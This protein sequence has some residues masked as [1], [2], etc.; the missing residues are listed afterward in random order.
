M[1]RV[2]DESG[3]EAGWRSPLLVR[4]LR[5]EAAGFRIQLR[6]DHKKDFTNLIRRG[7]IEDWIYILEITFLVSLMVSTDRSE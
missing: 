3:C 5:L 7:M 6:N 1:A 4:R 2:E